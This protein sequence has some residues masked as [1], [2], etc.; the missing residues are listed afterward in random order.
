MKKFTLFFMSLLMVS[1]FALAQKKLCVHTIYGEKIEYIASDVAYIDFEDATTDP[2]EDELALP[3]VNAPGEGKTTIVLYIPDSSCEEAE[4]YILGALPAGEKW[5]NEPGYQMEFIANDWWKVTLDALNEENAYNFKFRMDDGANGWSMEPKGS[6]TLIEGADQYVKIKEDEAN[7]LVAIDDCENQVL[8]IKSGK[9]SQTPCRMLSVSEPTGYENGY[10]Y[11]DLGL[12]SGTLWATMNVGAES[13]EGYGNYYAWGET[14]PKENYSWST[15]KW[16]YGSYDNQTRY[17]KSNSYGIVDNKIT[18]YLSDDAAYVN[19]GTSWR[20][21][22]KAEIYELED[23]SYTT[24]TWTT[25][26]GVNG[27]KVTSKINGNSIFLPTTGYR[28]DSDLYCAGFFGSYWSSSLV[29]D[30]STT[31]GDAYGLSM[32]SCTSITGGF[33]RAYG[34]PVRAVLHVENTYYV[35]FNSNGGVGTMPTI[36]IKHA[37]EL[38]IPAN[39]FIHTGYNFTGWNTKADGTGT[40]YT[41]HQSITPTDN[42]I[43]YAQWEESNADGHNWVDLGLPSGTK[44][45]TTNIGASTPEEYGNYYAWGGTSTKSIYDWSTYKWMTPGMS[46]SNGITAY[47]VDDGY[48]DHKEAVWYNK[49]GEFI[50]DN[51]TI[52]DILDDAAYANWGYSWRMPTKYEQDELRNTSYTTW[53]WITQNGVNGYKV[54]SNINGNSIFLPAAG[55]RLDSD[56]SNAGSIGYYWSNSLRESESS[57]AYFLTGKSAGHG[58]RDVG[59]SVRPVLRE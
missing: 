42:L 36:A 33:G 55:C 20:M 25:Q 52:L 28:E 4:P 24:W 14:E 16:C 17:C 22:T 21:P 46:S 37:D 48:R 18:L 15:Y 47:T 3:I 32:G 57:Y 7:N 45:A 11:V 12:P 27:Y 50:G 9:W 54:I 56:L 10:G 1:I 34:H 43:L 53:I 49:E 13:P 51:K 2:D 23:K 30:Y 19:W 39:T 35:T 31:S 59:R 58:L 8:Y 40:S 29:A 41:Y 5:S 6:Y 38:I 44:W 26:N